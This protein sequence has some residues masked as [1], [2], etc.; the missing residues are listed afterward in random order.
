M[1]VPSSNRPTTNAPARSRSRAGQGQGVRQI[2]LQRL[3][4]SDVLFELAEHEEAPERQLLCVRHQRIGHQRRGERERRIPL[5]DAFVA[6]FLLDVLE[7][8]QRLA[9]A[10]DVAEVLEPVADRIA[11]RRARLRVVDRASR[12]ADQ[13]PDRRGSSRAPRD[14]VVGDEHHRVQLLLERRLPGRARR[15]A[16][17][18][19]PRLHAGVERGVG[20]WRRE[21]QAQRLVALRA[22]EGRT[23]GAA[24]LLVVR[25]EG[26]G[27]E[28]LFV[29]VRHEAVAQ[30]SQQAPRLRVVAAEGEEHVPRVVAAVALE[31][32]ALQVAQQLL[33]LAVGGLPAQRR[34]ET[35]RGRTRLAMRRQRRRGVGSVGRSHRDTG[36]LGD[37]RDIGLLVSHVQ[38]LQGAGSAQ[39][40][41]CVTPEETHVPRRS[42]R[43]AGHGGKFRRASA[44]DDDGKRVSL[45]GHLID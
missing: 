43:K 39:V 14:D 16:E 4:A 20:R 23:E 12:V 36:R 37:G 21:R 24:V 42:Y 19:L 30:L 38:G 26:L 25:L 40:W 32:V 13:Q 17:R 31:D 15:V 1:G 18:D 6:G 34:I 7:Q 29:G 2:L 45:A 8:H 9:A 35:D 10:V 28:Q 44:P 33:F 27:G 5:R 3:E 41:R 11:D 22:E